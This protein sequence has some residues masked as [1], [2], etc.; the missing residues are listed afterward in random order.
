M[1]VTLKPEKY[2]NMIIPLITLRDQKNRNLV[3]CNANH[4]KSLAINSTF[5]LIVF[6]TGVDST[7]WSFVRL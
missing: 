2:G 3:H 1:C 5:T 6:N 4:G 7:L